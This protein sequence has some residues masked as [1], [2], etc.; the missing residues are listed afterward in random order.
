MKL[1]SS[2]KQ[3]QRYF[4][5]FTGQT[6]NDMGLIIHCLLKSRSL[7]ESMKVLLNFAYNK[8]LIF[9]LCKRSQV[10]LALKHLCKNDVSFL[11]MIK[12]NLS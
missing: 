1:K 7:F 5:W 11:G 10:A 4:Y 9:Y 3:V 2:L 12:V 6:E 8:S